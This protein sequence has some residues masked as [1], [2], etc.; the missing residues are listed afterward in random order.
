MA[1]HRLLVI[2]NNPT[3]DGEIARAASLLDLKVHHVPDGRAALAEAIRLVPDLI[4][5]DYEIPGTNYSELCKA[6]KRD[7]KLQATP[8][9]LMYDRSLMS[10]SGSMDT[11]G[12]SDFIT[13]PFSQDALLAVV[14]HAMRK[15]STMDAAPVDK[16]SSVLQDAKKH[17]DATQHQAKFKVQK[18]AISGDLSAIQL[19]EVLQL[20]KYQGRDGVLF[21]SRKDTELA[22]FFKKGSIAYARASGVDEE[23][24]LGR[25]LMELGA[26]SRGDLDVFIKNRGDNPGL[27]LGEQL[28]KLGDIT[29][30]DL[31]KALKQQTHELLYEAIRWPD[32]EFAFYVD[33]IPSEQIPD[34]PLDLSVDYIIMEGVRR[35]DEWGIIE[36]EIKDFDRVLAPNRDSTGVIRLVKLQA[37]EKA[38][39][40]LVDGDRTIRKIIHISKKSSFD[41][42]KVLY[43]L[44]TSR[45]IRKK[46]RIYDGE[47]ED[48]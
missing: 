31:T 14:Q 38:I 12:I 26:I 44:M 24:L 40:S 1:Q 16:S 27:L 3:T 37:E 28:L 48:K 19:T 22:V 46:T 8:V 39:L 35:V 33:S 21:L 47:P 6:L 9:I 15:Y 34:P 5:L 43:R 7:Q 42:C 10:Q 4:L 41:T 25:F 20:L 2:D 17:T 13:K 45:I 23:F 11:W 29:V 36:K 32:G 30:E 18:A